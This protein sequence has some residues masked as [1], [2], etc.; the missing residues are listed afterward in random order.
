MQNNGCSDACLK[1]REER[2]RNEYDSLCFLA[3]LFPNS[4]RERYVIQGA[5]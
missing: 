5:K 3:K 4:K 2:E 1:K